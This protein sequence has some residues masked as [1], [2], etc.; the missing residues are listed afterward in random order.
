MKIIKAVSLL[1]LIFCSVNIA[2]GQDLS[3]TRV[4][5]ELLIKFRDGTASEAART[6]HVSTGASI[7]EEFPTIGWQR[8]KLP[9]GLSIERAMAKY[10]SIDGVE[11]VQPN[12]YY[13]LLATPN[14]PLFTNPAMY[15]LT[16][17]GAPSA[18]DLSTG[19]SA[20]VVADIDTGMR[21]THQDLAANAWVNQA[22]AA[23]L[24]GVDDDGNGFVD[25][26]NGWD[27]FFNDSNP[28]DDAGGHGTHT[29]G[30]IGAVGNNSLNVVGVCWNVKIMPIKI[31]SPNGAD[32]T[33]AM[34]VN[35][36]NY[37]T[38]MKTRGVNIRATNNS[39]GGCGEA[40]GYDQATKDALDAMGNAGIV[41][42]F[43]AGNSNSN[44]DASPSYPVSYTSPSIIGVASSTSTDTRSSFSSYGLSTVDL[45]APGSGI[46]STWNT[47]NSATNTISGTSMATP[48]VTGAVALLSAFNPSLSA[49]SL[50]ASLLNNVDVLANWNG[51]VKTG[52]RL[53]VFKAMQNPTVCNFQLSQNS[54]DFPVNGGSGAVSVTAATNCDYAVKSNASWITVTAG[55]PGSGN[56]SF[57][58]NVAASPIPLTEGWGRTGTI[59]VGDKTFTVN[60]EG[61]APPPGPKRPF[62]FDGDGKTDISAIENVGGQMIWHNLNSSNGYT[63]TNFG[64]FA[65]DI[66]LSADFDFDFKADIAVWR[67]SNGDFYYLN[68]S[69]GTFHGVHFGAPGDNPEVTQDFDADGKSD[70]AVARKENGQLVWY[71]LGSSIGFRAYQFGLQ[72]DLPLRGEYDGDNRADLAVYRPSSNTFFILKSTNGGVIANTFGISAT[73]T[74][75]TGD[76]D[77]DGATDIA[78]WRSTD[79]VWYYLQSSNGA[80]KAFQFGAAG[81]LPAPGDYDGDSRTDFCVWRPA[82]APNQGVFYI[83]R[84][85]SGFQA[86]GWGTTGMKIPANSAQ[87]P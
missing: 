36:Y 51:L 44:N 61:I 57:T 48:H 40:C 68:S 78:V 25:D 49:A 31:Y 72:N 4:P 76:F 47:S 85:F 83:N 37:I 45:A 70:P 17:I 23:G 67:N 71:I 14:D 35:A 13:H 7:L 39:Y 12:F 38:M 69:D 46:L 30:T 65:D 41:S 10:G 60:Q 1:I 27:F 18:W 26:I 56:G 64:L 50:K 87:T 2:F 53:N 52:G 43:A 20:V 80:F 58:Y 62:D 9:K 55:N 33:S 82:S 59:S 75:V 77:G 29:A 8:I 32:S 81:D 11:F 84:S 28:I 6:S 19:S 63:A 22:E 54:A 73:D 34:L 3:K 5:G 42:A 86:M 66:P 24:G 15:G 79:G 16:K 74:P 21:Y